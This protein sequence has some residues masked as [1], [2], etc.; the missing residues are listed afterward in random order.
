MKNTVLL[1][2]FMS[3]IIL[4]CSSNDHDD[5]ISLFNGKDLT[6]WNPEKSGGFEVVDGEL[7]TRSFGSGND[8]YTE[9]C[10]SNFILRLEFLLSEVGNSGIFIRR[11][12]V[13]PG[14]GFEVQVLAPWTPWRDDLHCTGSLYG[15]V[16]VTNR[17]DETTGRWY[18]ME[19]KCDRNMVT[20]SINDRITT[21][22]DIDTVKSLEGK[23]YTGLI[24]LQGN[25]A[26]KEGQFA[27]F[28]NIYIR[29][30]DSGPEY[31]ISGFVNK[32]ELVRLQ[33]LNAAV[34]LGDQMIKPLAD[35]MSES[36]PMAKSGAKQALFDIVAKVSDP[37]VSAR[38]RKK[39]LSAIN[40]SIKTCSSEI[41]VNYLEW[42]AGM[43]KK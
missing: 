12:P 26:E 28:R 42:I 4:T 17:P 9:N 35:M 10:Y 29:N 24:G 33:A 37:A 3:L 23:P 41:T 43:I 16:A 40:N 1:I 36:D 5:F 6:G 19:I 39:V 7:I 14:T 22:A 25:H 8:I 38:E 21:S 15:H 11:D 27:K 2:S 30:L 32:N 31:V 34:S 13:E 20:V 18:K